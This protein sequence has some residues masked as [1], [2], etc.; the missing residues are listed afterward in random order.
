VANHTYNDK[1][2]SQVLQEI[3]DDLKEF[4]TTRFEMLRA[5]L[6]E[7]IGMIKVSLPMLAAATL[8]GLGA[9]FAF[10]YSL[11]AVIAEFLDSKYAWFLGGLAVTVFYAIVASILAYLGYRELTAESLV[12]NRTIEVLKQDQLWIKDE[13]TRA[14]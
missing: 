4:L 7:K 12:P 5:E 2:L 10:T 9:F 13:T 6:K 14:A 1:S 8:M 11:V 3:K